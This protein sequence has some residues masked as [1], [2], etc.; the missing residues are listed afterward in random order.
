MD[1]YIIRCGRIPYINVLPLYY[2]LEHGLIQHPF[3]FV[4]APPAQ[5]NVSIR[6]GELSISPV[7]SVEYILHASQYYILPNLSISCTKQV[8]SVLLFS[9]V[10][11]YELHNKIIAMTTESNT[12]ILLLKVLLEERFLISPQYVAM[13]MGMQDKYNALLFIGD[14]ALREQAYARYQY[15]YDLGELW[16][17]WVGLPF[18][19]ALWVVPRTTLY[20]A[21]ELTVPFYCARSWSEDNMRIIYDNAKEIS[22]LTDK[23]LKEY[24]AC[25]QYSFGE[26]E[27]ESIRYF[28]DLLYKYKYCHTKPELCFL[29]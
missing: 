29:S 22:K 3:H 7:S 27:Q 19:F 10:P 11:I 14:T 12:S 6:K 20:T 15:V 21:Q 17:E 9:H 24:Y 18:V 25:L 2:P 23:T 1:T 5:L 28:I 13:D 16:Y 4:Y 8:M 26:I